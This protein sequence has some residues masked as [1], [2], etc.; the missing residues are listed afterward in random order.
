MILNTITYEALTNTIEVN[1]VEEV[2]DSNNNLIDIVSVKRVNYSS[3]QKDILLS[4]LPNVA[5]YINISNW[6]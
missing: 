6:N 4:N 3:A 1:W 2:L 5:D